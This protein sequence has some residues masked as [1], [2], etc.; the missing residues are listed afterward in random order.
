VDLPRRPWALALIL[1]IVV[2]ACA[3][4]VANSPVF[5]LRDL[6]VVGTRHLDQADV[7]RLAGLSSRTNVLWTSGSSVAERLERS[8]WVRSATVERRLPAGLVIT[9]SERAPVALVAG[10]G[11]RLQPVSAD[12]V[13]MPGRGTS[14]G[15][16]ILRLA[17]PVAGPTT[18]AGSLQGLAAALRAVAALPPTVR[19]QVS[20]AT[21]RPDGTVQ[22]ELDRGTVVSFGDGSLAVEKGRVLRSLLRWSAAHG[23]TPRTIDVEVPTAPTIHPA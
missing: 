6:R 17:H 4:W 13:V 21:E 23:V 10:P 5:R 20:A 11:G 8:P 9:I 16:P 22:L 18:R 1:A 7:R 12:G 14:A 19:A 3:A 15:L 2:G